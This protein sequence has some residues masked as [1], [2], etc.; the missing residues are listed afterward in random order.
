MIPSYFNIVIEVNCPLLY[1]DTMKQRVNIEYAKQCSE[2]IPKLLHESKTATV[3]HKILH[4]I[5]IK[6]NNNNNNNRCLQGPREVTHFETGKCY[7][8][9]PLKVIQL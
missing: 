8:K 9:R 7:E 4:K 2:Q 6:Y 3:L 5:Y 1:K